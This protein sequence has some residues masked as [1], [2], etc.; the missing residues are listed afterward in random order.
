M[1]LYETTFLLCHVRL[2]RRQNMKDTTKTDFKLCK[3]PGL[4]YSKYIKKNKVYLAKYLLDF[5]L[6]WLKLNMHKQ[7]FLIEI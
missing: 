1:S 4:K 6:I 2:L 5:W 7:G 3:V